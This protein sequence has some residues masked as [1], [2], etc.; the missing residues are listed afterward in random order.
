MLKRRSL[1][2]FEYVATVV[3]A[4]DTLGTHKTVYSTLRNT[5]HK[6][7]PGANR[8]CRLGTIPPQLLYRIR[9]RYPR[10]KYHRNYCTGF[11]I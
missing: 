2:D 10:P 3:V 6:L 7:D 8:L 1:Q 9:I 11:Q 5:V 4:G